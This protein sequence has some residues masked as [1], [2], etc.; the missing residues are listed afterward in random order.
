MQQTKAAVFDSIGASLRDAVFCDLFAGAGGV[1]IEAISRGAA[2]VHF[3]ENDSEA[4][5]LLEVNLARCSLGRDRTE[6]HHTSVYDFLAES[7]NQMIHPDIVY[8]DP[9]YEGEDSAALLALLDS[10]RYPRTGMLIL[11]HRKSLAVQ[12][13]KNLARTKIKK[14]GGT[15]V[16]FFVPIGG[17]E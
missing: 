17:D 8:A 4:I 15:W 7:A 16:S 10:L 14:F 9:P 5:K 6:V 1:G 12:E 2:F 11:E 3:V 13:S